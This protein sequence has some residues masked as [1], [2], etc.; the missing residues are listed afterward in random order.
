[1]LWVVFVI[2]ALSAA[3]WTLNRPVASSNDKRVPTW[4]FSSRRDLRPCKTT[5]S[6]IK[7]TIVRGKGLPSD[8]TRFVFFKS[9]HSGWQQR[10]CLFFWKKSISS[11]SPLLCRGLFQLR[12]FIFGFLA[13]GTYK[14]LD[15]QC[16]YMITTSPAVVE[17]IHCRERIAAIHETTPGMK[18][19]TVGWEEK[20]FVIIIL[21]KFN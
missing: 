15:W 2:S 7:N 6:P 10:M 11:S 14:K 16:F 1:M 20:K 21:L 9:P 12:V 3:S 8:I 4:P 17:Q 13:P 5:W 19:N 18:V